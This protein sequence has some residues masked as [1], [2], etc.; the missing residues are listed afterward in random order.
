MLPQQ[1][2]LKRQ[3]PKLSSLPSA[4]PNYGYGSGNPVHGKSSQ[5]ASP[6]GEAQVSKVMDVFRGPTLKD[7]TSRG[8][9]S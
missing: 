9:A 2:I 4:C 8:N 6:Q 1:D 7:C 3:R 5:L